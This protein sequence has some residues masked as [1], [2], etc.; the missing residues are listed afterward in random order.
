VRPL[1][2]NVFSFFVPQVYFWYIINYREKHRVVTNILQLSSTG[3]KE[4]EKDVMNIYVKKN[5]NVKSY[6]SQASWALGLRQ[7]N[8]I[9]HKKNIDTFGHHYKGTS[10]VGAS[11]RTDVETSFPLFHNPFLFLCEN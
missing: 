4:R 10:I 9:C 7:V 11:N 1:V 6:L 3:R 2:Q 8:D 5:S